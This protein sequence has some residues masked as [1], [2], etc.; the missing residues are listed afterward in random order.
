M[1]IVLAR[2]SVYSLNLLSE[3]DRDDTRLWDLSD[4]P[5]ALE[6][7]FAPLGSRAGRLALFA[8]AFALDGR[9]ERCESPVAPAA[10]AARRLTAGRNRRRLAPL[11]VPARDL[12]E[13]RLRGV[14]AHEARVVRVDG[15][16]RR[17]G[18]PAPQLSRELR[19]Y[20]LGE[21]GPRR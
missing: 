1:H 9:D 16:V 18:E 8:H 11:G 17:R 3:S 13:E 15:V 7:P 14:R 5:A 4:Q 2:L 6:R 21:L 20:D 10:T 12:G 19:A